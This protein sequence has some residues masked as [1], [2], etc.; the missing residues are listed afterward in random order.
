MMQLGEAAALRPRSCASHAA[1]DA[2]GAGD[3]PSTTVHGPLWTGPMHDQAYVSAMVE[4]ATSRGW[5]DAAELLRTMEEEAVAEEGG[6]LLFYHLGEVQ[7]ELAT[8][9]LVQPPLPTLIAL[10]RAAGHTAAHSHSERKAIKTS[11]TLAQL[12]SCVE[13]H[14]RGELAES[15]ASSSSG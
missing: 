5:D 7:R 12:V 6:A 1:T 15:A 14:G 10:L 11:A 9:E 2:D 4:E 8:H 13:A 3:A